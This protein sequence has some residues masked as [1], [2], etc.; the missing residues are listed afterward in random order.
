MTICA[1]KKGIVTMTICAGKIYSYYDHLRW[2]NKLLVLLLSIIFRST[3]RKV[4]TAILI[5]K[6]H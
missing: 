1:G 5:M 2:K 4:V 3:F 6:N